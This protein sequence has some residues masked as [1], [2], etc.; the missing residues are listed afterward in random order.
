MENNA[1]FH[2][3][4]SV[5]LQRTRTRLGR[6]RVTSICLLWEIGPRKPSVKRSKVPSET[7]AAVS[8]GSSKATQFCYILV[9]AF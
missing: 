2:G 4:P 8:V 7:K 3:L 5:F 6:A 1:T 9:G